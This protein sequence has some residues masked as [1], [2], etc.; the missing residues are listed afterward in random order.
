MS[1][2]KIIMLV[3]LIAG[4]SCTDKQSKNTP[5]NDSTFQKDYNEKNR[6]EVAKRV[7]IE[8]IERLNDKRIHYEIDDYTMEDIDIQEV[9]KGLANERIQIIYHSSKY[10]KENLH[11]YEGENL[12]LIK[13]YISYTDSMINFYKNFHGYRIKVEYITEIELVKKIRNYNKQ[14]F[15]ADTNANIVAE[16]YP[17][18]LKKIDTSSNLVI[19]S[20]RFIVIKKW[21]HD[22]LP[23]NLNNT[24]LIDYYDE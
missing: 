14:V 23:K 9:N 16:S 17:W 19:D 12:Q 4:F 13:K 1:Y 15:F 8:K 18:K 3:I 11:N 5:D 6:N 2:R 7:W 24:V 10:W 22:T 20:N 21:W